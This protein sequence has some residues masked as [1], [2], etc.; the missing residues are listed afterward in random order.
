MRIVF[1]EI[2]L[3]NIKAVLIDLDHTLYDFIQA[4]ATALASCHRKYQSELVAIDYPTF[5][6]YYHQARGEI[7]QRLAPQGACRSRFLAFQ[8]WFEKLNFPKAYQLAF[9][10]EAFYWQVFID[11]ISL[12]PDAEKFL[13][14]TQTKK[15]GIAIVTDM[16]PH[17][18]TAKIAKLG[19]IDKIDFLVTSEEAGKEKPARQP[20]SL[21]LKKLSTH[22]KKPLR[23]EEVI[24]IGDNFA[25]DIIGGETFGMKSYVVQYQP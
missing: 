7:Q 24:M 14:D 3:T 6:A 22:H 15:I 5:E 9:Q 23:P 20:F 4:E 18:Q 25:K 13:T 17:Y 10:Y 12:A 11:S 16:Q 8:A 21:A 19:I 2:D 1:P